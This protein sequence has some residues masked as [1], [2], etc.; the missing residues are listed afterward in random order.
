M[1]FSKLEEK[2]NE[3]SI[4]SRC[5]KK[6]RGIKIVSIITGETYHSYRT[7]CGKRHRT[8]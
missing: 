4:C 3:K 8:Y 5:G 2:F 1:D 7:K 6:I